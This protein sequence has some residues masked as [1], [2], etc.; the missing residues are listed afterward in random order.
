M[1]PSSEDATRDGTGPDLLLLLAQTG[2]G[3][4]RRQLRESIR[5]AIRGGRLPPG[6]RLPSSRALATD[7]GVSRGVVVDAYAQ[8]I[9]EGFLV[10][11]KGS[12]TVVAETGVYLPDH[13]P[14]VH[15]T[16][17]R[18]RTSEIDLRPGPPDLAT[19]P[20]SAWAKATRDIL[21]S[22]ADADLGYTPPWG[23]GALR[24]QLSA[25]LAR[26]R[27]VM[28]KP[29][30]VVVVTGATQGITLLVR[31]LYAAGV[32]DIAV[33]A[34]SNPV[35][36]QV[37]ARYGV[38]VWDVPVDREGLVVDVL[39]RTPCRAVIVTPGHQ[40]PTGVVMSATRRGALTR[41]ADRVDG[42]VIEDDYD[43]VFRY[44]KMQVGAVQALAPARVALVGSVSKSLAPGLRLGWVVCP[45]DLVSNLR[46]A[47]RDDDFGTGVLEQHVLARL[48]DTGEYDRHVRRLRRHYRKRRDTIVDALEREVPTAVAEGYAAGLHLLLR[49]PDDVGEEEYV[50]AAEA[51][52]VAVL[53]TASMYGT[54]PPRPGVVIGYGRTSPTMLDEAARR[55]GAAAEVMGQEQRSRSAREGQ[56]AAPRRRPSTAVDYF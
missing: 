6:S 17:E 28:T 54:L 36:R 42:L 29:A 47:K 18:H 52:G 46:T 12:G 41:W 45:P 48:I 5:D 33:E 34:P 8:L 23:V 31:V 3:T 15:D 39:A 11:R 14:E 51:Q 10:S 2:H 56:P 43:T 32:G 7:L 50:A 20:R 40:Y 13:D 9:A 25:Y 22:V 30:S 24:E 49:L 4:L 21:R 16:V 35:Q 26:V 53:G 19:F 55:L 1:K 37:L 44:D 38:R 27:G